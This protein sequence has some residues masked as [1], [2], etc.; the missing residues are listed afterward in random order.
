MKKV[1]L[2]IAMLG[3]FTG[4]AAAQWEDV[5]NLGAVGRDWLADDGGVQFVQEAGENERPGD[6]MSPAVKQMADDDY[7][8]AGT[9][10]DPIGTVP[11]ENV[12]ERAFA[13]TDNRI[14]IHFNLPENL[15]PSDVF[16][17]SFNAN[18]LHNGQADSR[19]GVIVDANGTV[20]IPEVI[21][22]ENPASG[23]SVNTVTQSMEFT[24]ADVGFVGGAGG[25]NQITLTGVNYSAEGGGNW[26]GMN[27]HHLEV[28]PVPEPGA[29]SMM[30]CGLFWAIPLVCWNNKRRS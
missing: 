7:Y 2:G 13:G 27:Y 9:Y 1:V 29:M 4:S 15:D 16:R 23:L 21:Y 17:Y 11:E 14:T 12:I 22:A 24:A 6:P 19:Y 26:M 10:P 25:D 3:M 30:L 20:V 5:F 8:T 28:M 18:N